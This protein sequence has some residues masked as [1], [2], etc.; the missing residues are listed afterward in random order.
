MIRLVF[1]NSTNSVMGLHQIVLEE[2]GEY[3]IKYNGTELVDANEYLKE[4]D[5]G[6]AN[7]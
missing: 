2:K 7:G 6:K 1:K 3:V 5:N 4:L